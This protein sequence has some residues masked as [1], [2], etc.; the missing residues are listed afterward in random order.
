MR[1]LLA[2]VA[3]CS[4]L[5]VGP[6]AHA[7]RDAGEPG[8]GYFTSGNVEWVT[9]VP[10]QNDTAG[11]ELFGKYFYVTTSRGLTIYDISDNLNPQLISFLAVPQEPTVPEEDVDT[12]GKIL[13]IG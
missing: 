7:A 5:L 3:A 10:L 8:P 9:N 2:L 11:A 6:A 4:M 1:R 12:N 13:L